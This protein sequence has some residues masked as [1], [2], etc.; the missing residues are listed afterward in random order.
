MSLSRKSK[1]GFGLTN[2]GSLMA[3]QAVGMYLIYFYVNNTVL[4]QSD[5]GKLLIGAAWAVFAIWDAIN[6]PAIGQWSDR[7]RTRWGRRKPFIMFGL[8]FLLIF[9]YILWNPIQSADTILMFIILLLLLC[10][11][12]TF[13]TMST[14]WYAMYPEISTTMSDRLEI[15]TYL[16]IAG[17]LGLMFAFVVPSLLGQLGYGWNIIAL[18]LCVVTF[19]SF[20]MPIVSVKERPEF[21]LG[22]PLPFRKAL[23]YSVKNKSFLTYLGTQ[24]FLQL[25]YSIAVATIPFYVNDVLGADL[26]VLLMVMFLSIIP[27]LAVWVRFTNRSGP[28]KALS[29]SIVILMAALILTFFIT[30]WIQAIP[31]LILAGVGLAGPMLIPTMM[32]AD[33]CDEDELKTDVRREGMYT[34]ISGFIVK[35]STSVSGVIVTGVLAFSGYIAKTQGLPP[36]IEPASAILGIRVLMG[37]IAIIPLVIALLVLSKYPLVGERLTKLKKDVE[38]LHEEKA[39]KLVKQ[40]KK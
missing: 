15:S 13:L 8:P 30:D 29:A 40:G 36:P 9:Y 39:K 17:I 1:I 31:V 7:T 27:S 24:L 18:V 5:T 3:P 38:A 12:D 6:D 14:L 26:T 23:T 16:Q 37:L 33:V 28:R 34:G 21:S 19:L 22:K 20:L 2:V 4:G 35:L 25:T 32:V 11:Y 10:L